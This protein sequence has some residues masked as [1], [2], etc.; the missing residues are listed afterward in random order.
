MR[1]TCFPSFTLSRTCHQHWQVIFS[2]V[3]GVLVGLALWGFALVW[4]VVAVIM[5][6]VSG[7]FPFNM[8]WWG[9]IFP[10]GKCVSL[11]PPGVAVWPSPLWR[12][13]MNRCFH[14]VDD[15]S[16]RRT[17]VAILQDSFDCKSKARPNFRV[18][19]LLPVVILTVHALGPYDHVHYGLVLYRSTHGT[20]VHHRQDVLRAVPWYGPLSEKVERGQSG[21]EGSEGCSMIQWRFPSVINTIQETIRLYAFIHYNSSSHQ[22]PLRPI[23][24]RMLQMFEKPSILW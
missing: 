14:A 1:N 4:F 8:G 16:R 3:W 15:E 21:F 10:V 23:P 24:A 6:V 12:Y 9:F 20:L 2:M 18:F 11:V 19:H 22:A 17:R 7:G 5:I 13:V